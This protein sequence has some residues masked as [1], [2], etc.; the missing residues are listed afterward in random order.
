[1]KS[2]PSP[3]EFHEQLR[4]L[5]RISKD[6]SRSIRE[7]ENATRQERELEY[8]E[9]AWIVTVETVERNAV[10][11]NQEAEL[12]YKPPVVISARPWETESQPSSDKLITEICARENYA[13]VSTLDISPGMQILVRG[14]LH[15]VDLS[16]IREQFVVV[17]ESIS[18]IPSA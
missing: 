3:N 10:S 4:L 8:T 12:R 2:T 9:I 7:R 14:K 6:S 5:D 18:I 1:M 11:S 16:C 17:A 13:D 15:D